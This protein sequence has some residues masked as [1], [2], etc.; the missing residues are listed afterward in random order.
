MLAV[1]LVSTC[2][3]STSAC[4]GCAGTHWQIGVGSP[5]VLG[6]HGFQLATQGVQDLVL[7]PA[8]VS[9]NIVAGAQSL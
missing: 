7:L 3:Q 2:Y 1:S 5:A 8:I 9:I 4:N 6:E